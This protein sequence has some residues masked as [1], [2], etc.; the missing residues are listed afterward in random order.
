LIF[1]FQKGRQE[2]FLN[3]DILVR[4]LVYDSADDLHELLRFLH[5][6][7]D[8]ID[9]IVF[10]TQDDYFHFIFHDPR[11]DSGNL[12]PQVYHESNTQGV[13]IMYR[14][15]DAPR[16]FTVLEDHNF[17]NVTCRLKISLADSFFP[18]NAGSYVL[19]FQNG[20]A[21]VVDE[22]HGEVEIALDIAEFSSLVVGAVNFNTLYE[23]GLASLSDNVYVAVIDR[24]FAAPKPI[25]L[26]EF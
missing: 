1:K 14:I 19:D 22:D 8:Q 10:Y 24:L 3:N 17:G 5:L 20:R 6:Q 15:I 11:N 13:G 7:A 18:E 23:Y 16:L 2:N 4:E 12:L 21:S 25:C 26:T 9:R